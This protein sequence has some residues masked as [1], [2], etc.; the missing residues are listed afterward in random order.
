MRHFTINFTYLGNNYQAAVQKL[1]SQ[2]VQFTV[3]N[4]YPSIV[5]LPQR[6]VYLS[7]P[8]SDQLIY[9]SFDN[10]QG[11]VIKIIGEAIFNICNL[12]N[13]PIHR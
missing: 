11:E 13:I 9:Q 10:R 8:D 3:Y 1:N 7:S 6:L 5:K 2:P 12:R 4:V